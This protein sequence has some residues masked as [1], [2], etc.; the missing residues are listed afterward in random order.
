MELDHVGDRESGPL[1]PIWQRGWVDA[2]LASIHRR[3]RSRIRYKFA[4][5]H[6]GKLIDMTEQRSLWGAETEK[7][8]QEALDNRCLYYPLHAHV[9][10][11]AGEGS[12]VPRHEGDGGRVR[13]GGVR[14]E[15]GT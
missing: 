13:R 1:V 3:Q 6:G 12:R 5:D 11:G 8:V 14:G 2:H 4:V 9:P 10:A 7:A 15:G